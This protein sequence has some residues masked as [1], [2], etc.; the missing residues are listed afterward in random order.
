M[1]KHKNIAKLK[2]SGSVNSV[3][4]LP[5]HSVSVS[6][7]NTDTTDTVDSGIVGDQEF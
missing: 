7:S 5:C 6:I 3:K 4:S 2:R 1:L